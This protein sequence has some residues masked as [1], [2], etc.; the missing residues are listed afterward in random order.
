MHVQASYYRLYNLAAVYL[1]QKLKHCTLLIS[2][3]YCLLPLKGELLKLTFIQHVRTKAFELIYLFGKYGFIEGLPK[4]QHIA[5]QKGFL[6]STKKY[7]Q[8][9]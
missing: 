8:T 1:K 2:Y 9:V 4:A 3:V 7:I 5:L 6:I